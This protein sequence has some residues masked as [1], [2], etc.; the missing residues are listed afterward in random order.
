MVPPV[1]QGWPSSR[2]YATKFSPVPAAPSLTSGRALHFSPLHPRGAWE[3]QSRRS[4][5]GRSR[6]PPPPAPDFTATNR[7]EV[8]SSPASL[9]PAS[10]LSPSDKIDNVVI[11]RDTIVR[12]MDTA[13]DRPF[14]KGFMGLCWLCVSS[15]HQQNLTFYISVKNKS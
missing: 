4:S 11:I 12:N 2:G 9:F 7:F 10:S 3:R 15:G 1:W 8:L 5:K 14:F 13:I 6:S